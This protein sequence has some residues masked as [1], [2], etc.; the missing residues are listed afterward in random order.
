MRSRLPAAMAAVRP[1]AR[2]T[3]AGNGPHARRPSKPRTSVVHSKIA[4]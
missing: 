4:R 2:M 3:T 1:K